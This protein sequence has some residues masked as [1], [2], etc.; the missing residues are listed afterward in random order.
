MATA[1]VVIEPYLV[2]APVWRSRDVLASA[3]L[4]AAPVMVAAGAFVESIARGARV[5]ALASAA[6]IGVF[7][8]WGMA[9]AAEVSGTRAALL[10]AGVGATIG[11]AAW[12]GSTVVANALSRWRASV[13][14]GCVCF[15]AAAFVLGL[16]S[17]NLRAHAGEHLPLAAATG[18]ALALFGLANVGWRTA[19]GRWF[20]LARGVVALG[21]FGAAAAS[22]STEAV[23]VD[24]EPRP[25]FVA[26]LAQA[27]WRLDPRPAPEPPAPP[28]P[29]APAELELSGWDVLLITVDS[30]RADHLGA[31]G[32]E[33]GLTPSLDALAREGVVFESAYAATSV[34]PHAL[35][36]IMTGKY[37]RSL[38]AMG[39]GEESVP[40]AETMKT[41][42]Y[43]T[44]AF[45]PA[46]IVVPATDPRLASFVERKLGFEVVHPEAAR[47]E[48]RS[49]QVS[50]FLAGLEPQAHGFAWVHLLEPREPYEA[51]ESFD[52]GARDI[53]RYAAEVATA[54]K[55][56]G[57]IVMA[58]RAA[59]SKVMVLVTSNHGEEFGDHGGRY[60]G[61]TVYEEQVR[62]PLIVSAP[63][64]LAPAR[65]A[66][67]AQ[68]IDLMPTVLAG[69]R[70]PAPSTLRGRDL[71]SL[72]STTESA[73]PDEIYAES[74][75]MRLFATGDRRLVCLRRVESC[76]LYDIAVD[77]RQRRDI[78]SASPSLLSELKGRLR[79]IE[80]KHARI[81][82]RGGAGES[83]TSVPDVLAR[84]MAGDPEAAVEIAPLLSDANLEIR[85]QAASVLFELRSKQVAPA[86]RAALL[87]EQDPI[88]RG[89]VALA[90]VRLGEGAPYAYE[91][92]A[93]KDLSMRRLAALA[94]AEA[95]DDRGETELLL[96]WLAAF[97]KSRRPYP[98]D[99]M[100]FERAKQ[101]A[102][103]LGGLK[104]K[105]AVGAMLRA[106][107]D[108]RLRPYLAAA[109]AKVGEDAARPAL[110]EWLMK[111]RYITSRVAITE[112]LL[113]L[114][115]GPE[116]RDPLVSMLGMPD[117]IPNGLSYAIRARMLKH[118]GGPSR[119][120]ELG[121]LL[122]FATSGVLVDFVVPELPDNALPPAGSGP[123]VRVL[124][125][126]TGP[127]G[128]EIHIGLRGDVPTS[129]EKKNPIP[130]N[131][132]ALDANKSVTLLI[133]PGQGSA[134]VYADL[135]REIGARPKKSLSLVFYVTQGVEIEACALVPLR[136]ELEERSAGWND[137]ITLDDSP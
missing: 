20:A 25:P 14:V 12:F 45:F 40:W 3:T 83:S 27:A 78:A 110:A 95:G 97:P 116:L 21:V 22:V 24:A 82:W 58:A 91:L 19:A 39:L 74:D 56:I 62:V 31:Y 126:A 99:A 100:T 101:V 43:E 49:A 76:S 46:S 7:L 38:A 66:R 41:H 111:E 131:R 102:D 90:L 59:R 108:E 50:D 70:F 15:G 132:P 13:R 125:R 96:W 44:A 89:Y 130:R 9:R 8:T 75:D 35:T 118:I 86:L 73:E 65:I 54:D 106:L 11:F 32:S 34:D 30:L 115:A 84:G 88:V 127:S 133:P 103:A 121:R 109:L 80:A 135:P 117:P 85:K 64:L 52:L 92:A 136:R 124:C 29:P 120:A 104:S 1:L 6:T 55:A 63:G 107:R 71:R 60:H 16:E 37:M 28:Q 17:I 77:P 67:L 114:G 119:N 33:R 51:H 79:A 2:G 123:R 129:S 105:Y 42:G 113:Q 26:S 53:D 61:S 48:V 47:A 10:S 122:R 87:R 137:P 36:S 72:L 69:L 93:G 94:L 23:A 68:T 112:A 128:G 98:Q 134:E 18:C 4:F 57:E 5:W 81:E